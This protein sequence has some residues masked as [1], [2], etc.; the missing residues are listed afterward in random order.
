MKRRD[1]LIA[2]A[3][4]VLLPSGPVSG[5]M[6]AG[7]YTL[8]AGPLG[9]TLRTPDGRTVFVYMTVKPPS[10]DMS[11]NSVCCF[12]PLNTPAANGSRCSAPAI[13][14]TAVCSLAGTP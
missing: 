8:T 12:A 6:Q 4:S 3:G 14:I 5:A 11:A 13:A 10:T 7:S 2:T 1:F 9:K